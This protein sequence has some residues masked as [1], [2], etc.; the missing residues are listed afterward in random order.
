MGSS[1]TPFLKWAG[2]KSGLLEPLLQCLPKSFKAYYEPFL[3]G[4]ALFF[5]LAS[6]GALS[7]AIISDSNR[8]L[9]NC[10]VAVRDRLEELIEQLEILQRRANDRGFYESFARRR[11][12][13]IKLKTGLEGDVEKASLLIYLNKT[14]YNGLYRVNSRSE[15]NVPWG[16][17]R[18]PRIFD[19]D[20]LREVS[21]VLKM[22]SV[23]IKC[24]DYAEAVEGAVSGDLV[25]LDPPYQPLSR[26]SSFTSYTSGSFGEL[27]QRR[28]ASVFGELSRRSCFVVLSNSYNPLI[29]ELYARYIREGKFRKVLAPRQISCKGN[30]RSSVAEYMIMS[31]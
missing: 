29:E 10:Y 14:C 3:G 2:G 31:Y 7:R 13:E 27:D 19:P 22:P 8:D 16:R 23:E 21:K 17:Y 12:N 1:A 28:L 24:C 20:N 18:S 5:K 11:F 25:Y 4:G 15:F 9:I 6:M 30:G 26:T